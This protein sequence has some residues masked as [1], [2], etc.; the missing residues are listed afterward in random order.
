MQ[1]KYPLGSAIARITRMAAD[2]GTDQ[3]IMSGLRVIG[4]GIITT[5][6]GTTATTEFT[7]NGGGP[8]KTVL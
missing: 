6:G 3:L 1:L 7:I 4:T 8:V 5:N 2:I